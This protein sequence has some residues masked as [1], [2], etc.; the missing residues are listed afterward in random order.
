VDTRSSR[1]KETTRRKEPQKIEHRK[2]AKNQQLS[3]FR[4]EP[5]S[6]KPNS[7]VFWTGAQ[8][9]VKQTE[10]LNIN[11][12]KDK[13]A[14][15]LQFFHEK[16]LMSTATFCGDVSLVIPITNVAQQ[17]CILGA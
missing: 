3:R 14:S 6:F 10:L 4:H 9:F 8:R 12:K 11:H 2:T 7:T 1:R 17:P 15:R 5:P 13:N 16:R